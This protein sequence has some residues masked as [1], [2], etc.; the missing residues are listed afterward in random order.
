MKVKPPRPRPLSLDRQAALARLHYPG[1]RSRLI[2]HQLVLT[3]AIR[4]TPMS[5]RYDI[6]IEYAW[7]RVPLVFVVE[8]ALVSNEHGDEIPHRYTDA[9]HPLCL[10]YAPGREWSAYEPL[11]TTIIPW[12]SE[13]L[14]YYELWHATREWL[15]GGIDHAPVEAPTA[16]VEVDA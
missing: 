7:N 5:E 13:W 11:S 8:P 12:A 6:R 2:N 16:E 1:F 9:G 14:F 10:F 4:P 15:G 3:G